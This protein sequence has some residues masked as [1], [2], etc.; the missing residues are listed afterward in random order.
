M[1][2]P[3]RRQLREIQA[4]ADAVRAL[5]DAYDQTGDVTVHEFQQISQARDD[6][7]ELIRRMYEQAI[8]K[9]D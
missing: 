8:Y 2:E 6:L 7:T 3:E 1:T 4:L 9:D 5:A